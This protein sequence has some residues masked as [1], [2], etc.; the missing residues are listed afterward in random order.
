MIDLRFDNNL[1]V[2]PEGDTHE[3]ILFFDTCKCKPKVEV[4]GN[5]QIIIHNAWDG[6]EYFEALDKTYRMIRLERGCA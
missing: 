1:H 6:R 2:Y 4:C 5:T 3:H